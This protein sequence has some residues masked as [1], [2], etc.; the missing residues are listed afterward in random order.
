[1]VCRVTAFFLLF[2]AVIAIEAK[3]HSTSPVGYMKR[4]WETQD[5]LPDQA[6]QTFAQTPDGYLWIGTKGGLLQFDGVKF[7][8]YDREN[9]PGITE[10][11]VNCL[12][13]GPDGSLWIGTE[14]G[15]LVRYKEHRFQPYLTKDGLS[16]SFVRAVF[17]DDSKTVWVGGDQG[18]FRVVGNGLQ[19]VDGRNGIP[20]IFVRAITEDS[21]GSVWVGG[22]TLLRFHGTVV[23]EYPL[24]NDSSLNL[25][26]SM[27]ATRA[28]TLWIGMQSGLYFM[29]SPGIFQKVKG[30]TGTVAALRQISNGDLWV[31]TIGQGLFLFKQGA[32]SIPL[33]FRSLPSRTIS[34]VFE[35][36]EK[37]I[38]LGTQ[39][40]MLRMTKTPVRIVPLPDGADSE[41]ETVYKDRDESLWV[42]VSSHLFR[43]R[44]GVAKPY[45]IPG[46]PALRVRTV[47]RDREGDLWI[48]TDGK[49]ILRLRKNRTICYSNKQGLANDFVRV[50][51]QSRDGSLWVGTDGG[52]SHLVSGKITNYDTRNGLVYFSV[53]SLLED[54]QGDIWVGTSRGL[55]H[56]HNGRFVHDVATHALSQEKLWSIHEDSQGSLWFG[57][58]NGLYRLH[59]GSMS[60][61]S[62]QQGLVSN[63]IY[64]ILEDS[65]ENFWLSGPTNVSRFNRS[66][67]DAVA[68]NPSRKIHLGLYLSSYSMESAELYGGLQPAGCITKQGDV[69]FPSNKGPIHVLATQTTRTTPPPIVIDR[70][71]ADGQAAAFDHEIELKPGNVRLE[72]SYAAMLL[73]SQ[74]AVRYRYKLDGLDSWN[75]AYS[76][77]TAYYTNLPPGKYRFRVQAFEIN[78]P[79]TVSEVAVDIVQRPHF[80]RT[81]WFIVLWVLGGIALV[82]VGYQLRLHQ[83]RMRFQAVLEERGR[84]AREMHDTLIQGCVGVS[85]LLE[86]ATGIEAGEEA[87]KQQLLN[88]ATEQVRSTIEEA[89]QAVWN[90]RNSPG[91]SDTGQIPLER[92][93]TQFRRDYKISI[94]HQLFGTPFPLNE[95]ATHEL[96]MVIR[97]AL[98]NAVLHGHPKRVDI[99]MHFS[100]KNVKIVI[101]DD[102]RGFDR[103]KQSCAERKH[104]GLVGMQERVH[105]MQG[106][107]EIVSAPGKGTEI[108][109][110]LPRAKCEIKRE[111]L[112]V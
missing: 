8:V 38:W 65:K 101:R 28:G 79:G 102:G 31:G 108:H 78:N 73:R 25:V 97:E 71:L 12:A 64:Q 110:S 21:R 11:S 20:S 56:L 47:F 77:T 66:E 84:L 10:S 60:R 100:E 32:F 44:D 58:S 107:I 83:M 63:V 74:E 2:F 5:G 99:V 111:T 6:V 24:P 26:T 19:R 49:G 3:S 88:Y 96:E 29:D 70:V 36:S 9:T 109:V 80:Y 112:D 30:M 81:P 76:R 43:V 33:A 42:A 82:L 50:I 14:G 40:G 34:T 89:R 37:N 15:G 23:R 104:Y 13:V 35:D 45:T 86:A 16:N 55:S 59:S 98:S 53:T 62:T 46:M 52:L 7:V 95:S 39:A 69:W 22:T 90:L 72:I 67:L 41:F 93:L 91:L 27:L 18:L 92:I 1:M 4:L 85:S 105:R 54:R 103:E 75:E 106:S 61:F 94:F 68:Q 48:G 87:L 57:T 51:L 17:V